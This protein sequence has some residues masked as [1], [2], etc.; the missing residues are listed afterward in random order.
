MGKH[1]KQCQTIFLGSKITADGDC[2]HEIKRCLLL[3]RKVMTNLDSILKNRDITWPT[4]VCLVKA[5]IFPVV[6]YGCES[7][8]IKKV[9]VKV[10]SCLTLCNPMGGSLPGSRSMG[11]SRQEYWSGLPFP[12]PGYLPNPGIEPVYPALQ[13]DALLSEPLGKP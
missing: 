5:M 8:T 10:K 3:G 7:R 12:S 2:S 9:K 4:K 1:W 13:T 11:F 6:M